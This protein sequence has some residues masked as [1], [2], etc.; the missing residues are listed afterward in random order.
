MDVGTDVFVE[1]DS[2]NN[3]IFLLTADGEETVVYKII[4]VKYTANKI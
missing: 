4:K 1:H 2:N 3:D